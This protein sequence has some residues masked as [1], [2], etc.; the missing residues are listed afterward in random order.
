MKLSNYNLFIKD[1]PASGQHLIF[2]T[3]TQALIKIDDDFRKFLESLGRPGV[4]ISLAK[5]ENLDQLYQMGIVVRD[6]MDER[7]KIEDFFCQLK[8]GID[9]PVLMTT[10]LTTYDCNFDCTYCFE[11]NAR[12]K[13]RLEPEVCD[14]IIHWLKNRI[15]QLGAKELLLNYYGGE[16]LLNPEAIEYIS[17]RIKKW[18]RQEGIPF[19]FSLQTNGYLL[20]PE[21]VSR[22]KKIGLTAARVS[23][24]GVEED[25]DRCRKL[26]GGQGTF[27]RIFQNLRS[28]VTEIQIDLAVGYDKG[29]VA[30]V[31][32]LLDYLEQEGI[33][34]RLGKLVI[35]PIH[36]ML[37]PKDNPERVRCPECM[38]NYGDDLIAESTTRIN[39]LLRAKGLPRPQRMGVS[40]CSL[41]RENGGV[42]IDP[43]GRLY[44]CNSLLGHTEFSVGDVRSGEFNTKHQAFRDL[45]V[46]RQCPI[47]CPYLPMCNGGCR[48]MSF[49]QQQSFTAPSCKKE[50]LDRM[51]PQFIKWEYE[52]SL[53]QKAKG[54]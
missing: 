19:S 30:P 6:D 46:W 27:E 35:A 22:L 14:A 9:S 40:A 47:K 44:R 10:I 48:L 39:D 52:E 26:K 29:D 34:F 28:A 13:D 54:G 49:L 53:A 32:R 15:L 1:Y 5:Q 4:E 43:L 36:P 20:T 42:T 23:L 24:D 8:Y 17:S 21:R 12:D 38:D 41:T 51:T 25:H 33:L 37:G 31:K 16:P 18:C 2:N 45:D 11:K 3:R 7:R 50:F